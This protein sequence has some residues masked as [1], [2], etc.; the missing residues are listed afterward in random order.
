MYYGR[1][2]LFVLR[3]SYEEAIL[4]FAKAAELDPKASKYPF[5]QG[6]ALLALNKV[7]QA[8]EQFALA[9]KNNPTSDETRT[10]AAQA[11]AKYEVGT[12]LTRLG[13]L[14][15]A[16][17]IY[18]DALSLNPELVEAYLEKG[19]VL[20]KML[21]FA[22]AETCFSAALEVRRTYTPVRVGRSTARL[23]L[24]NN[25][26]ALQDCMT[27]LQFEAQNYLAVI[28]LAEVYMAQDRLQ[29]ALVQY[30]KAESIY[31][32]LPNAYLAHGR[33][34]TRAGQPDKAED[35]LDKA[36]KYSKD[37]QAVVLEAQ[38]ENALRKHD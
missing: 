12:T 17:A 26:G 20:L 25:E 10:M 34:L 19:N 7:P 21:D 28:A 13:Q 18:N 37:N 30:K 11:W 36:L 14:H 3:H 2:Q 38:A 29:D 32:D 6:V 1:G 23:A 27:A 4:D 5:Q 22:G 24:K 15:Q 9:R 35:F 16:L 33:A 31:P 8:A